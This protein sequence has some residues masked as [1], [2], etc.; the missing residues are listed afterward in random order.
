MP[1][2]CGLRT[3]LSSRWRG[4]GDREHFVCS[5]FGRLRDAA[6]TL[7]N[8]LFGR[9]QLRRLRDSKLLAN[10]RRCEF[11]YFT[12][13][14]Y[15]GAVVCCRILPN[16]M[17]SPFTYKSTA[18]LAQVLEQLSSFHGADAWGTTVTWDAAVNNK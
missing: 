11:R 18:V 3:L 13:A 1:R 8:A 2:F 9:K 15:R 5:A 14:R 4:K 6:I 17:F 12:V 10:P 16:R 7:P